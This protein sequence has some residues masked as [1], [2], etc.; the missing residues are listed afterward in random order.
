MNARIVRANEEDL[1]AISDLAGKIWRAHY[2][3]I[4]SAE[5][6]NYMLARMYSMATLRD[7][8]CDRGI[9]YDRLL[10]NGEFL[11]FAAYGLD[12][13]S[14]PDSRDGQAVKLHKLYL[15]P[16]WHGKGLGSLLLQHCEQ[17]ARALGAPRLVLTV[18]KHNTKAISAYERNAFAIAESI[19]TDIGGGFVMDDF[20]MEKKLQ[21]EVPKVIKSTMKDY[22][23]TMEKLA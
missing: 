11:G 20:V 16:D 10:V 8:V 2:P 17:E 14:R 7:E 21:T 12:P 6:I 4:I 19:V 3:G 13:N 23:R 9:R 5:Q 22:A 1:A 15:H 18:N